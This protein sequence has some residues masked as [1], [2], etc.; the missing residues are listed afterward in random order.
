MMNRTTS[1]F[2]RYFEE[3]EVGDVYEHWP[4]KT[5]STFENH[6]FCLLT[7]NH[8]PVH[9][10]EEYAADQHHGEIL[11]VGPLVISLVVGMSVRDVSG[12]AIA[13][14]QYESITHD[15]PV[16]IGDTIHAESEVLDKRLSESDPSQGI[17]TV[18]TRAFNQHDEQVLSLQRSVLV[19]C[20]P[21]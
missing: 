14:L 7:M 9:I 21:D 20:S 6:M 19:S 18:E 15:A 11:V 12:R 2:G 13:N 1:D 3:F 8:H 5:V 16:F 10:D 4:G 17:V